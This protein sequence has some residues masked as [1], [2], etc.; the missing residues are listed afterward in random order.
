MSREP[1]AH[2]YVPGTGPWTLLLLHAT[3]GD[4][5]QL[6][7]L[8]SD[9][10]PAAALLAPRG[11]VMEN[12]HTRRFFRRHAAGALDIP[13]LKERADE[14]AADVRERLAGYGR[15]PARV[16]ALGYSNGANIAVGLMFRDPGLLAGAALLR[17]ML[18]YTP[19]PLP[20]LAGTRVLVAAGAADPYGP[21]DM[22]EALQGL[23]TAAGAD[24]QVAVQPA[25][26]ELT[27]GDIDVTRA[28]LADLMAEG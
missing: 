21:G 13:D 11:T 25:G 14:L 2:R 16:V 8:A 26:H 24:A 22:T 17:P 15:D 6:V 4:E 7:A 10:A 5:H 19:T 12:G 28:W 18:P 9:L 23:L 3:G 20:A 1:L 27:A